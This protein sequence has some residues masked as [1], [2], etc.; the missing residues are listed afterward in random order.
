MSLDRTKVAIEPKT[1]E[2]YEKAVTEVGCSVAKLDSSVGALIWTDYS[3]PQGL[4]DCINDN[5]QLEFVQLPF[6]G[7]DA[8]QDVIRLPL[9]F[10]C[11]KGSYREPV[12][13]HALMLAMALGRVLPER[14]RTKTW[15]RK[16]AD[17]LYDASVLIV[18]AGG[19]T[20]E[21][22][23]QLA[24]FR[25]KITVVRNRDLPLSGADR[26]LLIDQLDSALPEADWVFLACSLT[27]QTMGLL[28]ISRF[29]RMKPTAYLV[30][31]ARG[32]VIETMD[33]VKALNEGLIAGAGVDVTE[34]EPLPDG[35]PLWDAKNIIITP[36]TADTNA[37]VIR[38][39]SLRIAENLAAYQ[40]KGDW[41]GL[42][43]P[44][45]G[46]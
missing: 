45:L 13:E 27:E 17:S 3:N 37:Q 4:A 12:A 14:I 46:Y 32:A 29:K 9:R 18:G 38:L 20:E 10:A 19:I 33:L 11:A 15:G 24:A 40:G 7:V 5:P 6:A 36:H 35:H 25:C 23:K 39:F 31:V 2:A 42:V 8:F 26:V 44:E 43:D 28:N 22:I 16:H 1:H 21:L 30:N 34:P 41:V